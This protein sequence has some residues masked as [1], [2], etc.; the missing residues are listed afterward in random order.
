VEKLRAATRKKLE[1]LEGRL[2]TAA[3]GLA[4]QKAESQSAKMQ[5]GVSILGGLLGGLMGRKRS[6]G[7]AISKGSSA[8]KQHQDVSAAEDKVTAVQQQMAE[9]NQQLEAEIAA[10]A[11]SFDPAALALET[12]SL[13]P[14][15]SNVAVDSIALLWLP[16]DARGERAW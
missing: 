11:Q 7:S 16:H 9:L 14:T 8:F 10:L 2:Q 1:T 5:A 6:V 12:E 4:R 3:A 13:K 15:K